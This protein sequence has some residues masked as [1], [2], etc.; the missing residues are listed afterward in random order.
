M[1]VAPHAVVNKQPCVLV[2]TREGDLLQLTHAPKT[3]VVEAAE[4]MA[5]T[6]LGVE[7]DL[8]GFTAGRGPEDQRLVVVAASLPAAPTT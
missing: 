2:P 1:V 7:G 6:A 3:G 8:I 5:A 4:R